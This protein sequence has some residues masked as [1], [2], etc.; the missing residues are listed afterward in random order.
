MCYSS[1]AYTDPYDPQCN[2][3]PSSCRAG[4]SGEAEC[5]DRDESQ[6]TQHESCNH[7]CHTYCGQ[8]YGC[9]QTCGCTP[10]C[11]Q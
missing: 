4:A 7:T 9:H 3:Q 10:A 2:T 5:P 11:R 1:E 8:P 6:Q